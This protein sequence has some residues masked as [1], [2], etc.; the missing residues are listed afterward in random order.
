MGQLDNPEVQRALER[1]GI[2]RDSFTTAQI[3]Q[4]NQD[5]AKA[6]D[7]KVDPGKG[8]QPVGAADK[9]RHQLVI[10]QW[11][12]L[13]RSK[14]DFATVVNM[15][16]WEVTIRPPYGI[17]TVP[18][19]N[20]KKG[21]A[22]HTHTIKV[23]AMPVRDLGDAMFYPT[24]VLPVEIAQEFESQYSESG[25]V[26]Y[27]R[28]EAPPQEFSAL[29]AAAKEKMRAGMEKRV[30]DAQ[31]N[32]LRTNKNPRSIDPNDKLVARWLYDEGF[33]DNLPEWVT[34]TRDESLTSRCPHCDEPIR[35]EAKVCKHCNRDLEVSSKTADTPEVSVEE[36]TRRV[37][38]EI[39]SKYDLVP[40]EGA[41]EPTEGAEG[42]GGD[43]QDERPQSG[44][45]RNKR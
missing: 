37:M 40:K 15:L 31:S 20:K 9:R 19:P 12:S 30:M 10:E 14:W 25:G 2:A 26:F 32:W 4:S 21:E 38:A 29:V 43:G 3:D 7:W 6:M 16:P 18:A 45:G 22:F 41:D 17:Y 23:P 5:F 1:E 39:T 11:K 36:I 34:L 24:P 33:I 44:R 35:K 13:E 28:G 27:Y 8:L 42:T